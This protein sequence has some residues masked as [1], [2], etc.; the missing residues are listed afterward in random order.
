MPNAAAEPLTT[1]FSNDLETL[2]GADTLTSARFGV[3]VSGGPDSMAL[4]WLTARAFPGRAF[5]ATVDHGLR[6]EARAEAEMVSDWCA[7]SG[8]PHIT[9]TPPEKIAGNIQSSAR[10]ARYALLEQ[11]RE[12]ANIDWLMTAHHADDQLETMLMRLNRSSGV[13]GLAAIRA[14]NGPIVRPLLG[15]RRSEL[16]DIVARHSIPHILDPSNED[17]RFD[18]VAMR[19]NLAGVDW[20]DPLAA[21]RSAAACADA[22]EALQW[23]V[24]TLAERHIH[25]T[26]DGKI[27]LEQHEFPKEIIRRLIGRMLTLADPAMPAPRGDTIDQAVVQLLCGK[28]VSIGNWLLAGG[29]IWTLS[30]APPRKQS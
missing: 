1:R 15:W 28:Q 25:R 19:N 30:P 9:L 4:L 14:R 26:S 8:I 29:D 21:S 5:A 18:R 20:L 27:V 6:A 17:V 24:T 16:A 11:W 7:G 12:S 23:T 3:A 2:I 13:G 22:E 10:Q